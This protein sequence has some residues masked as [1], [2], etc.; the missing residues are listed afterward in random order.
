M[1]VSDLRQ[2][3]MDY[4]LHPI[5]VNFTAAL[6]PV[7]LASDVLARASGEESLGQAAWWALVYAGA[8][9]PFTA[10]TGWLFWMKDDVGVAGMTMHKWLGTALAALVPS[11]LLWRWRFQRR[12]VRPDALYLA[13]ALA[14]VAALVYQGTLGGTQ[15]FKDM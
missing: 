7:S 11:L 2:F 4:K 9:T 5:L 15:V 14:V 1:I 8:V 6:V 13:F 10:L 3:V 12:R